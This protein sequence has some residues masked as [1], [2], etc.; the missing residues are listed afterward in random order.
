MLSKYGFIDVSEG[1]TLNV[2]A[3]TKSYDGATGHIEVFGR[4]Y[5]DLELVW[6]HDA[7]NSVNMLQTTDLAVLQNAVVHLAN[8]LEAMDSGFRG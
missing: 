7:C 4:S 1:D 3:M 5:G 6:V 2:F 8:F